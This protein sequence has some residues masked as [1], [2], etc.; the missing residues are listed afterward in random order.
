MFNSYD[1][2]RKYNY[3]NNW[4][5]WMPWVAIKDDDENGLIFEMMIELRA[6]LHL[7]FR[8]AHCIVY[9]CHSEM[10]SFL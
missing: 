7:R 6:M 3:F 2:V 1:W 4:I 10:A 5:N 8:R 9:C